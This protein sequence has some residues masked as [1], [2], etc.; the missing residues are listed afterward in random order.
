MTQ[1]IDPWLRLALM[2]TLRAVAILLALTV[3]GCGF[4]KAEM[5][6]KQREIDRLTADVAKAKALHE[7]DSRNFQAAQAEIA[8][9]SGQVRQ[10]GATT[11]EQREA[12]QTALQRAEQMQVL[13]QRF[14][15]LRARLEKLTQV[16]VK[17]VVRNNRMV[18]QMPGDVLFDSGRDQLKDD[19]LDILGQVADVIRLDADLSARNFQVA[20][21]T[22]NAKY[23][24]DG[25]FKDN[26]G[27]SLARARQVLLFLIAPASAPGAKKRG[28]G[29]LGPRQWSASGYGDQDPLAGTVETQTPDQMKKN[30]RV[31]LVLQP[32]VDE[33]ID[34]TKLH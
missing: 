28:G 17:F 4:S 15:D 34:L 3:V 12:L 33:M 31:E 14:R 20:G 30:R 22:D 9:L 7:D 8:A 24:A 1:Q 10:L 6:E 27:L 13:E 5:A 11:A 25:P 29:G 18:I 26:W 2:R 23:P 19:G 32:N 16:G 21:H